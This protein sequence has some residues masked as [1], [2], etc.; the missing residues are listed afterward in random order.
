MS[1]SIELRRLATF[2]YY[3]Y[4]S[5]NAKV[6]ENFSAIQCVEALEEVLENGQILELPSG[7]NSEVKDNSEISLSIWQEDLKNGKV[8]EALFLILD[9]IYTSLL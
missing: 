9:E 5:Y 4:R 3:I 1:T 6:V 7:P 2:C 8:S